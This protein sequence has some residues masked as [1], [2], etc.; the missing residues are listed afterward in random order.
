MS[1]VAAVGC[2][3]LESIEI[4]A[5]PYSIFHIDADSLDKR[6]GIGGWVEVKYMD[7]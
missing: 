4:A 7:E 3:R 2:M 6:F 1:A 5:T